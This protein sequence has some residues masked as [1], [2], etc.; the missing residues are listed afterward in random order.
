MATRRMTRGEAGNHG[1]G[2]GAGLAILTG[3][4]AVI[5]N[6]AAKG[7]PLA[8]LGIIVFPTLGYIVGWLVGGF[9]VDNPRG[10][11]EAPA[12]MATEPVASG[13][14]PAT[15][16]PV[17][18]AAPADESVWA[19]ALAEFDSPARRPGLWAKVFADANGNESV[20]KAA[21]LR[22]RVAQLQ[23]DSQQTV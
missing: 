6:G 19:Q 3:L 13:S 4:T 16:Q 21:Y 5:A 2:W 15:K 22:E 17:R 10:H 18:D 1:A 14:R 11:T 9:T 23:D 7:L 8:F 20:A 12:V